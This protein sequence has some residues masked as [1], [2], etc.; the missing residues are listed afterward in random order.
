M[1]QAGEDGDE[2]SDHGAG[3]VGQGLRVAQADAQVVALETNDGERDEEPKNV[4]S[5]GSIGG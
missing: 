5:G 2:S 4:L 1:G 3:D